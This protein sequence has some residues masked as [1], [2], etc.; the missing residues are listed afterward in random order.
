MK[1]QKLKIFN[2][3]GKQIIILP[4]K[5]QVK[6]FETIAILVIFFFLIVLG[7]SFYAK[8]QK[9]T[10]QREIAEKTTDD[11]VRIAQEIYYL[12]ELQYT[13]KND[14]KGAI[15]LYKLNHT[16]SIIDLNPEYYF[17]VIGY[18]NVSIQSIYG[19]QLIQNPT[20]IYFNPKTDY[21]DLI[22]THLPILLYNPLSGKYSFG[23]IDI[24]VYI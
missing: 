20:V 6:M 23:V 11:A 1:P 18:A 14:P 15:D 21:S 22:T 17:N 4:R 2:G 3:I 24:G 12:P 8:L 16:K 9:I 10:A 5:S 7:F 19:E 13:E